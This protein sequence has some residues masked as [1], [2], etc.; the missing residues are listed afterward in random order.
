MSILFLNTKKICLASL[1]FV[2]LHPKK[3]I[4]PLLR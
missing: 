3:A 4:P 1:I 2:T